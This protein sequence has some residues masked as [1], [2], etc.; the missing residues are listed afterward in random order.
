MKIYRKIFVCDCG[1]ETTDEDVL[2]EHICL[3]QNSDGLGDTY[4]S[5]EVFLKNNIHNF[6]NANVTMTPE[7]LIFM[8]KIAVGKLEIERQIRLGV[9]G[10]E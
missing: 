1:F 7:E 9:S 4:Q 3:N 2:D 10:G 6:K 8:M 5:A